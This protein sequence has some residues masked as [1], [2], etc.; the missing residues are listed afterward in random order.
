MQKSCQNHSPVIKFCVLQTA[1]TAEDGFSVHV[2]KS[3]ISSCEPWPQTCLHFIGYYILTN[4]SN[5][6]FSLWI[7]ESTL[8]WPSFKCSVAATDTTLFHT[9]IPPQQNLMFTTFSP[10]VYCSSRHSQIY[11]N[12]NRLIL[13]TCVFFGTRCIYGCWEKR[14]SNTYHNFVEVLNGQVKGNSS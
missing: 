11:C 2:L 12:T 7:K 14:I 1:T 4:F 9:I 6:L 13:Y 8:L 3:H 10:H 5:S